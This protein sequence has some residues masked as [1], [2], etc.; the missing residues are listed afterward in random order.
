M[1]LHRTIKMLVG[2]APFYHSLFPEPGISLHARSGRLCSFSA[3]GLMY[4]QKVTAPMRTHKML[5]M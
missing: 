4:I 1:Q 2:Q 5:V 3:A